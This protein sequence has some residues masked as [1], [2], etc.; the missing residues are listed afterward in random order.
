MILHTATKQSGL[1]STL[2]VIQKRQDGSHVYFHFLSLFI[3]LFL[4]VVLFTNEYMNTYIFVIVACVFCWGGRWRRWPILKVF[5]E[6]GWVGKK[7]SDPK[8]HQRRIQ[9]IRLLGLHA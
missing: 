5:T 4:H 9:A 1:E 7:T 3:Y 2:S 8:L 6:T